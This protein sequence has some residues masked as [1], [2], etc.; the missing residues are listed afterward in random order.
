MYFL[1]LLCS[2]FLIVNGYG[3][4]WRWKEALKNL[5]F[6]PMSEGLSSA[7]ILKNQAIKPIIFYFLSPL[8]QPSEEAIPIYNEATG[9]K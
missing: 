7:S 1:N 9:T 6:S 2:S 4:F 3:F 8:L 5:T